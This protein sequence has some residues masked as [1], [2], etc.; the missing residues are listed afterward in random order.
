MDVLT[1]VFAYSAYG[2]EIQSNLKIPGLLALARGSSIDSDVKIW[3][4]AQPKWFQ[5]YSRSGLPESAIWY[6]GNHRDESGNPNI[7]IWLIDDRYFCIRYIDRTEFIIDRLSLEIWAKWP[8]DLT[9]EDTATY[10]LGPIL[11]FV[12]RLRNTL[13]FHASAIAINDR[14]LVL[15]GDA[16]A[17][18]STTAAAFAQQGYGILSDDVVAL[19]DLGGRYLVQPAYPRIRLWNPSVQALYGKSDALQ[20]IVPTH[21]TWDK[22]YV[23]LTQPNYKFHSEPLPLAAIYYLNSR[24]DS[25]SAPKIEPLSER[26]RLMTLVANTYG[27]NFLGKDVRAQEF[28]LLGHIVKRVPISKI[29]PHTEIARLPQLLETILQDFHAIE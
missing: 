18:K 2:V 11:G 19:A 23:D 29:T 27:N 3:L 9:L 20:R 21:P 6:V 14:V 17:G 26:E 25:P 7:T 13:C 28:D 24:S 16:G 1:K 10:L 15:I 4:D 8:D 22:R 12:L 5:Q